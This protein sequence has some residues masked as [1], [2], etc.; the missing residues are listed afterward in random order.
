M[1]PAHE[2]QKLKLTLKS[3]LISFLSACD[4]LCC[5]RCLFECTFCYIVAIWRF[6]PNSIAHN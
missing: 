1:R 2:K 3:K 6:S 5:L 4:V